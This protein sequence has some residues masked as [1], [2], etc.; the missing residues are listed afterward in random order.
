[1]KKL[2]KWLRGQGT[3]EDD[4]A[5]DALEANAKRIA[6]LEAERDA[7]KVALQEWNAAAMEIAQI[8][9]SAIKEQQ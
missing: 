2:I 6:E 9:T 4:E 1:M 3:P 5:A 7:L 8:A